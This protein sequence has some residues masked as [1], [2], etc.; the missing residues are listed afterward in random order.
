MVDV[1]E[2]PSGR[3]RRRLRHHVRRTGG[4]LAV[5]AAFMDWREKR[6][7][8]KDSEAIRRR[9]N[10]RDDN[11][12]TKT[13]RS[14]SQRGG[15]ARRGG[16]RGMALR[17]D[18]RGADPMGARSSWRGPM[19]RSIRARSGAQGADL[20]GAGPHGRGPH[21][22]RTRY[23]GRD[24]TG[25]V[26]TGDQRADLTGRGPQGR[27]PH[28]AVP[29]ARTSQAGPRVLTGA[30][31]T[32]ADLTGAVLTDAH[33]RVPH[34]RGPH[35]RGPHARP[36]RAV[37]GRGPAKLG[38]AFGNLLRIT[39]SR[40]AIIAVDW[41]ISIGCMLHD[42]WWREHYSASGRAGDTRWRR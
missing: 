39:G 24:L 6:Q 36:S 2:L 7:W 29:R 26:L 34:G 33:G 28:G 20:T 38:T 19:A 3:W 12:Y 37:Q 9:L 41:D 17:A 10:D 35:G 23:H 8:R 31:L 32:D 5:L 15:D 13:V 25:A 14:V 42:A 16:K 21:R 4:I 27:G 40:H 11:R 22:A 18:L 1:L 30:V